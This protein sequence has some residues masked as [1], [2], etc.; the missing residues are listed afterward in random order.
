MSRF[1][2]ALWPDITV[3][4]TVIHRCEQIS[5]SGKETEPSKLHITL[6]FLG[7]LNVNQQQKIIKKAEAIN[8]KKFEIN[9]TKTGCFKKTKSPGWD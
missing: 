4:N 9:L 6:L 7:K 2:F 5:F 8:W 3:R 1:F